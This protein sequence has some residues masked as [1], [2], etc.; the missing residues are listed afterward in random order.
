MNLHPE[1]R[2]SHAQGWVCPDGQVIEC[3]CGSRS[4]EH[5]LQHHPHLRGHHEQLTISQFLSMVYQAGYTQV[6]RYRDQVLFEHGLDQ[7]PDAQQMQQLCANVTY[8]GNRVTCHTSLFQ[9][10]H[11]P[12]RRFFSDL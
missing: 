6:G 5:L 7:R 10:I 3:E 2:L 12:R 9:Q 11:G 1:S 8:R 4:I